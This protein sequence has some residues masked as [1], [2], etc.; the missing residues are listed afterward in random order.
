MTIEAPY[1]KHNKTN[2][3]IYFALCLGTAVIFA[4]DGYLSQYEWS[5]RRKFFEEH[6][7]VVLFRAGVESLQD[8]D[9]GQ[10]PPEL[11]RKFTEA[12][13]PLSDRPVILTEEPAR[14]WVIADQAGKYPVA[15]EDAGLAVYT[16][17]PD[18]TML[19]NRISPIFFVLGAGALAVRFWLR[20]DIKLVADENELVVA[21][22]ERIPYDAIDRIDR[23]YFEKKGFFTVVYK[24]QDGREVHRKLSDRDYDNLAPILDHLIAKIT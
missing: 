16:E 15:R 24:R 4:Y 21:G 20:K 13:V 11:R 23:T 5:H 3:K 12:K 14:R 17:R 10:I 7:R 8:L 2:F 19:F 22:R 18:E 9:R 6:N 1:S